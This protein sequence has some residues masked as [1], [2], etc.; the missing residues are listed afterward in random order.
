MKPLPG[1]HT[2]EPAGTPSPSDG[3]SSSSSSQMPDAGDD[4]A[5]PTTSAGDTPVKATSLKDLG[6]HADVTGARAKLEANR[7]PDDLKVG[8]FYL[9]Q[10]NPQG[11][12]LRFKDAAEHDPDNP[13][14]RYGLAEA[15]NKLKKRD[16]AI[17]N[18]QLCLA[19]D[20]GGDHDKA[21]RAALKGLGAAPAK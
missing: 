1:F 5:P 4:D 9:E 6:S 17:A 14:A 21:V 2:P 20:P 11:A 19:L 7:V 18:Y 13:E 10:G 3:A 8:H 12:Y 15:A 16:E